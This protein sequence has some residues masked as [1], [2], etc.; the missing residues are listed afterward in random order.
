MSL[1]VVDAGMLALIQD[2]GRYGYQHIGV[3]TGGPMDEHAFLWA[4]RLL[5]NELNAPQVEITFGKF[6]LLAHDD[7]WIAITGADLGARIN[8]RAILPWQTHQ[9]SRGDRIDFTAPVTGLRAYLAVSGG[10]RPALKLG[11]CA[12]VT[13][14]GLGGLHGHGA[15]LA[16]GD[17]LEFKPPEKVAKAS[18]PQNEVP[19]YRQPLCLGVIPGYQYP[20]FSAVERMKF[21]SCD[22]E[23]SQNIDRMG[24]R[25][26]GEAIHSDLSGIVSEG[27]AYGAI[28]VPSDGQPIVLMKDRQTIGGY[29]KIGCLSALDAGQLAQRGP[30][31]SVSFYLSDVADSEASRMLFNR[32]LQKGAAGISRN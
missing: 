18:V 1:E 23:V 31:A 10:F 4:N 7:T 2:T 11:S 25:L 17:Q 30:G 3:T 13:R 19:D 26:S 8:D 27:I 14:E 24:Y 21:F 22:Y 12:T 29:P 6:S 9:V 5:N 32:R 16:R 15:K 20:H 28:Q